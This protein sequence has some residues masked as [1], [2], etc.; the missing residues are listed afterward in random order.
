MNVI[1]GLKASRALISR[2][3]SWCA[4]SQNL[5]QGSGITAHCVMG[6]INCT[7]NNERGSVVRALY[8]VIVRRYEA[9]TL[10]PPTFSSGMS[11]PVPWKYYFTRNNREMALA[12]FNNST[13]QA[14]VLA[15]F[16]EAIADEETKLAPLPLVDFTPQP[17]KAE[18][19]REL[20]LA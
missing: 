18:P 10:E 9:G 8:A 7:L 19:V 4:G 16:D 15:L 12:Q 2:P 17:V 1:E 13:S 6:A 20:E 3:G 5:Y 11:P 14:G